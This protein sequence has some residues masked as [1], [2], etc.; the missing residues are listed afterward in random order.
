MITLRKHGLFCLILTLLIGVS[1]ARSTLVIVRAEHGYGFSREPLPTLWR[2]PFGHALSLPEANAISSSANP[3]PELS[4]SEE[5]PLIC[6][7]VEESVYEALTP[8]LN[9]YKADVEAQGFSVTIYNGSFDT[10]EEVRSFLSSLYYE[11]LTGCLLVGDIPWAWYEMENPDPWGYEIFPID[12]FYMDLNG[13][14]TD[15]DGDGKYD[16]HTGDR[17]PEI[18]VGR[19]KASNMAQDEIMLLQNYFDKNHRYRT[20]N[21][22][23]PN[24]AL[25]YIDDDWVESTYEVNY[26]VS[27]LY[28]NRTVVNDKATTCPGDYLSRLTQNWSL[29]HL[30]VHGWS[31]GHQFMIND[32]WDGYVYSS[33]I[34]ST[35]PHALFY[36]L[37]SCSNA[38]YSDPDYIGGCYIFAPTYGLAAVSSTK[39]GGMWFFEDFYPKLKNETLGEAFYEW[40]KNRVIEEE[41]NPDTWYDAKWYYGMTILGDPTLYVKIADIAVTNVDVPKTVVG[42]GYCANITVTVENKDVQTRT[43]NV[44]VNVN[45]TAIYTREVT[46]TSEAS[47]T[48]TYL[49]NTSSFEKGNYTI[50]VYASPL[51]NETNTRN[52][53]YNA[54]FIIIAQIGDIT[55]IE[56]WPDGKVDI[57]DIAAVS[58]GFGSCLYDSLYDANCDV[59]GPT[60]G[61]ADGKID[62]RD[63]AAVAVHFG[64]M[65][66]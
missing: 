39:I 43:F 23:M 37:Y 4:E 63:I 2:A 26:A 30:M 44:S 12:L 38:R 40:L 33:D 45:Q 61:V 51:P 64:E 28:D 35:D 17:E 62:I 16:T 6:V 56:G 42:Q 9:Q 57:R 27:T 14:W 25:I 18:W 1:T 5:T 24:N 60:I 47:I 54:G 49:W 32:A 8:E 3:Q 29:V 36:N 55:G 41:T 52:N 66:F 59:T 19:L 7:L 50:T 22:W 13:I 34:W 46:L 20:G 48:F 58:R 65:D 21:L 15:S 31:G 11:G 53:Q 10:A